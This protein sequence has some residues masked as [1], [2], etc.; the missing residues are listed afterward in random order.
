M[1]PSPRNPGGDCLVMVSHGNVTQ[2]PS[3]EMHLHFILAPWASPALHFCAD[4]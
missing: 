1:L 2:P 4:E 3:A